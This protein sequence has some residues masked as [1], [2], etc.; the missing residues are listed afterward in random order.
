MSATPPTPTRRSWVTLLPLVGGLVGLAIVATRIA[1]MPDSAFG[2]LLTGVG[3]GLVVTAVIFG[4]VAVAIRH[5]M[6][7]TARTFPVAVTIPITVGLPTAAAT[8]WAAAR[9]GDEHVALAPNRSAVIAA[10]ASGVHVV[11]R[12]SGPYGLIPTAVITG[13]GEARTLVGSREMDAVTL[14]IS[15]DGETAAVPLVPMRLRGNPF[16]Q[17]T[18]A[19][20]HDL[21]AR[22]EAALRGEP[23]EPGWAY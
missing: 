16:R 14:T 22:L 1:A 17:L 2:P 11:S 23:V 4:A 5:R 7:V 3:A 20:R 9:V 19:E 21:I 8:R 18:A 6:R 15:A 10:D 13:V 12:T